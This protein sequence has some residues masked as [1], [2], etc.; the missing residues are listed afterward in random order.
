VNVKLNLENILKMCSV[1]SLIAGNLKIQVSPT[2]YI[3]AVMQTSWVLIAV[4]AENSCGWLGSISIPQ[5]DFV[6]A[7]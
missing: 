3:N 4:M 7:G 2:A 5:P 1:V 6:F